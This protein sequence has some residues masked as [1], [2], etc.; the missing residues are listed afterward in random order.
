[1][2]L[3]EDNRK[4][5]GVL[6]GAA[7]LLILDQVTKHL[8]LIILRDTGVRTV[9]VIPNL[10][11]FTYLENPAAAFGLFGD[12]IWLVSALTLLV[13][14]GIVAALYLYKGHSAFSLAAACLLLAGG[15][16]NLI[17]R[18]ARGFVVDF[19]H[20]LFFG[21]IFNVADCCVTIGAVCLVCHYLV[22]MRRDRASKDDEA[23]SE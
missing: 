18:V 10:L 3:R 21:Y 6:L 7:V 23:D 2:Q 1:M 11:D 20:V 5:A 15:V 8:A 4:K 17:D 9:H 16:G 14:V 19:I 22:V 13:S 12:V